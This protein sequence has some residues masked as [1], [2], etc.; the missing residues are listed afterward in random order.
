MNIDIVNKQVSAKLNI[1]ESTVALINGY[2]WSRVKKH[3]YD[4]DPRPVNI[5]NVCVLYPNKYRLKGCIYEYIERL[6]KLK[7]GEKYIIGSEKFLDVL[8]DYKFILRKYLNLR[9]Y[10]KFTN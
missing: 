4:Y 2:Y 7:K 3:I 5:E 6:R 9:K 10:Y 1:K 8:E